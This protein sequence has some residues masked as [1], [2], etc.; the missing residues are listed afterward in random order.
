M[1]F[2]VTSF[3]LR[4]SFP[5]PLDIASGKR[6]HGKTTKISMKMHTPLNIS[7]PCRRPW[8]VMPTVFP[9]RWTMTGIDVHLRSE[10]LLDGRR[11]DSKMMMSHSRKKPDAERE[12]VL[13][14]LMLGATGI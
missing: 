4:A 14:S 9:F 12:Y 5:F 1:I 8:L 11:Y 6:I 2:E 3:G 10:H 13:V 7:L